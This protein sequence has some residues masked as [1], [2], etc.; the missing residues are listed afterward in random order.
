MAATAKGVT[1]VGF[2]LIY[3]CHL[4][5]PCV[6]EATVAGVDEAVVVGGEVV[7][8]TVEGVEVELCWAVVDEVEATAAALL[9]GTLLATAALD[10]AD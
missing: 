5:Y 3:K 2:P 1:P 9:L 6:D 10:D 4:S 7:A 8:G